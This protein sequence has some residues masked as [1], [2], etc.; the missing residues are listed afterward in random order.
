MTVLFI[1]CISKSESSLY[2][3]IDTAIFT[4]E[5]DECGSDKRDL[6]AS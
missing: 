4:K 6:K 5:V 1:T 3:T 2:V